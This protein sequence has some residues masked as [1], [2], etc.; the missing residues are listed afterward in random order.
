YPAAINKLIEVIPGERTSVE[1]LETA[2]ELCWKLGKIPIRAKDAPGFAVNRFFVPFLNESCKILGEGISNIPT[3]EHAAKEVFG[4]KLGPFELMNATGV[5]IAYHSEEALY[6][7]LGEFYKP[8]KALRMQFESN[9]KWNL[10]GDI[11][12]AQ[13]EIIKKRFLGLIFNIVCQIA[14]EGIA[15]REDID[16]GATVGLRW[17]AG[18]FAMMNSIGIQTAYELAVE[19]AEKQGIKLQESLERQ[20][21]S[22][23]PWDIRSVKFEKKDGIGIIVISRA[24]ALN[25]LN[26]RVLSDLKTTLA[27]LKE[28]KSTNV[29]IITGE[30]TAFVAGADIAEMIEKTPL[31]AREFTQLGQA[32]LKQIEN[33][34]KVVIAA[35]NG[36][37]LGGGCELAL[38]CDIIIAS[39]D[40]KFGLPEVGLGI[41]PGFGGTQ[42]LPRL[43]GRN[44]AKELIFTGEI[45][46]AKEAERI[47]LVNKIVPAEKLMEE[48]MKLS[49]KIASKAPV[50]VRLAKSAI[51]IGLEAPLEQALAYELETACLTFSTKDKVEGMKAFMEKRKPEFKGE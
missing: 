34:D 21:K 4:I 38:A 36:P 51:N 35:V 48:T 18:P 43:I 33:L 28:D 11:N 50:A 41:H 31:S 24:E 17:K 5:A 46:D 37:A 6:K 44:K 47:G 3:I 16:R 22:G 26:T 32:T 7:A 25:A 14:D 20:A 19:F 49:K 10:E 15:T 1:T 9:Q 29:V 40:A 8:A 12:E 45:I 2:S 42:R 13:V 39:E 23:L 27:E 30:G